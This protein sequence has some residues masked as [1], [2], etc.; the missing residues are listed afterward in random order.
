MGE[1]AKS[2]QARVNCF[3]LLVLDHLPAATSLSFSFSTSRS[4]LPRPKSRVSQPLCLSSPRVPAVFASPRNQP[5]HQRARW[6]SCRRRRLKL[7][8]QTHTTPSSLSLSLSLSL[9]S[10]S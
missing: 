4:L 6:P 9:S 7:C 2:S 3:T 8:G 5:P 1:R 10:S